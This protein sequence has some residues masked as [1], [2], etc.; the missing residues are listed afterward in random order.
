MCDFSDG[1]DKRSGA[2]SPPSPGSLSHSNREASACRKANGQF[3]GP[4]LKYM[5]LEKGWLLA[6]RPHSASPF[7]FTCDSQRLA[8]DVKAKESILWGRNIP[9]SLPTFHSLVNKHSGTINCDM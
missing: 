3:Q 7:R 1:R 2:R 6:M 9:I 4:S 5:P 8:T